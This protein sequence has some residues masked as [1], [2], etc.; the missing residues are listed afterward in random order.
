MCIT[1]VVPAGAA[2]TTA[3]P[4]GIA[5]AMIIYFVAMIMIGIYGYT[6]SKSLDDYMLGGRDLPPFVAA[7]S[8]GAAD[9]SGWLMM[10]LPG[11]MYL[12]GIFNG[13][14]AIGLTVGAWI[15][16]LV[17]APRLRAYT[18]VA[19]D[20]I[21]VPSFF[22]NR[23]HDN[24]KIIRYVAGII[25]V[26]FFTLYVS[27]GMV[28]GGTFFKS[29]FGWDYHVGMVFVAGI[30]ILY[31]LVGG[32][33]A[34]SWTDMVQGLIMMVALVAV[35]I[36]GLVVIG[37]FGGVAE[38]LSATGDN[39]LLNPLGTGLDAVGWMDW[40]SNVAWGFGYFGMPHIIV[41]FMALRSPRQ[42]TPAR[43]FWLGWMVFC[44]VGTGMTAIIGRA[45]SEKGTIPDLLPKEGVAG[46]PQETVFLVMGTTLFPAIMAGFMLA[47]ILAA[48]MSTVSSQLL[49]TSSAMVEDIYHGATKKEL[50]DN[51]GVLLGR[52]TVLLVSVVA[53][54]LAIDPSNSVLGLVSFAW[55]GFG[56]AFGPIVILSLYWKKL[57]W[58]GAAS[59][60]VMGA[61]VAV[62]WNKAF[63]NGDASWIVYTHL[64]EIVPG[65]LLCL[66]VAW[67]VSKATWRDDPQILEEFERAV[68]IAKGQPDPKGLIKT[69]EEKQ[70]QSVAEKK[71]S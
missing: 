9:M 43:R 58:Q 31:T 45:M 30:V 57:T 54:L 26:V 52:I 4:A 6:R 63:N 44:L 17:T 20:S 70:S 61:V 2:G 21:T 65:F 55:A 5:I 7:L 16:W 3:N 28:A 27:S 22:S 62:L 41:R 64:Y 15:N 51:K 46:N 59:G 42:A 39:S 12:S 19:G 18:E 49:V 71:N 67:L 23:T 32:F 8:A 38:G 47:A 37:G 33:L 29:T 48:I 24:S 60:M 1:T 36:M 40:I 68:A 35:P 69:L 56:A 10:G 50:S 34:V 14:I 53:A 66:L 13:W 25:I 11:A